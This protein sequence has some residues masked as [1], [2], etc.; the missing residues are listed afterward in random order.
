MRATP[1]LTDQIEQNCPSLAM[2]CPGRVVLRRSRAASQRMLVMHW[3]LAAGPEC[4]SQYQVL[5][6]TSG[7]LHAHR[8]NEFPPIQASALL[9]RLYLD[10][11]YPPKRGPG[12]SSFWIQEDALR[13][14]PDDRRSYQSRLAIL[15][16]PSR[17]PRSRRLRR[18]PSL[19]LQ[20]ILLA[21]A[22]LHDTS[23]HTPWRHWHSET[24]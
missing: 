6:R 10:T 21:T 11:G 7:P 14:V 23:A 3:R 4:W 1:T 12:D 19:L 24:S 8:R 17:D 13:S 18:A 22:R 2:Q 20:T 15:Y 9:A 5:V 16:R